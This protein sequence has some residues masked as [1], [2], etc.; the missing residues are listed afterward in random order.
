MWSIVNVQLYKFSDISIKI[1]K[2]WKE[3][4]HYDI[5]VLIKQGKKLTGFKIALQSQYLVNK[6]TKLIVSA[7]PMLAK[8]KHI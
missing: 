4:K 8:Q 7:K 6:S 1:Q 3:L 5:Q 2:K